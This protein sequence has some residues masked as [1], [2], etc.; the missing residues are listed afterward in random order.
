MKYQICVKTIHGKILIYNNVSSYKVIDGDFL[1]FIDDKTQEI[2]QYHASN[3]EVNKV[4][5]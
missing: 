1:E 5:D 2:K 4:E 3:C